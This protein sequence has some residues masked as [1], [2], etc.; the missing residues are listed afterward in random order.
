M[1]D[2]VNPLLIDQPE[3]N[4]D[5]CYVYETIVNSVN[6]VK[7]MRQLIFVTHNPNIP[8]LGD[9]SRVFVMQSDGRTGSVKVE[10]DVDRCRDDIINLLEGGEKAFDLR[11]ERSDGGGWSLSLQDCVEG[12]REMESDSVHFS[13]FSPPFASL[14][15]YSNS[16][17]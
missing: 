6:D 8:V 10:G 9:A 4:L 15:T 1:F 11:T 2:R 5:N 14:Y 13:V 17:Y 16:K 7:R 12:V 3:D